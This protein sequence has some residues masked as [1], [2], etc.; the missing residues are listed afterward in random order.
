MS[1]TY[2]GPLQKS[3]IELFVTIANGWKSLT[4][5]TKISILD[6][7]SLKDLHLRLEVL[8]DK[9]LKVYHKYPTKKLSSQV[10]STINFCI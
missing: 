1:E 8:L 4:F 9:P 3:K 10:L 5:V 7:F 2:L 6:F